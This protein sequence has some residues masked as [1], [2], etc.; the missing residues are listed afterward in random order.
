VGPAPGGRWRSLHGLSV[1]AAIL[2][3]ISAVLS[4]LSI[5]AL[6][7]RRTVWIANAGLRGD[8]TK[9][10]DANDLAATTTGFVFLLFVAIAV[11]VIIWS[12]RA[13]KNLEVLGRPD[14]TLSPGWAIGGWFIPFANYVLPFLVFADLWRAGEASVPWGDRGWKRVH[15][16][17]QVIAWW[18]AFVASSLALG[19]LSGIGGETLD[20]T[21]EINDNANVGSVAFALLAVAAVLGAI[22][23]RQITQRQH[24]TH[25][26]QVAAGVGGPQP[27]AWGWRGQ[28]GVGGP[29]A[30]GPQPGPPGAGGAGPWGQQ[31]GQPGPGQ[32]PGWGA[33]PPP[34]NGWR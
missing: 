12:W 22:V 29:A 34:P 7:H 15:I 18:I 3:A 31:P 1:A 10:D 25:D 24:A 23:L 33:P 4:L 16:G 9:I 8:Q 26:A 21:S 6:R 19:V 5:L 32:G 14:P 27:G 11:L 30:W 17:T 13:A 20:T 28:A 2:L